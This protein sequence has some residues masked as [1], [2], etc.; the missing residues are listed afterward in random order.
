M[1]AFALKNWKYLLMGILLVGIGVQTTRLAWAKQTIAENEA[2]QK[3]AINEAQHKAD[4]LAGDLIIAQ[5]AAMAVT[6]KTV[7]SY[8]DRIVKI[9]VQTACVSSA[10]ITTGFDGVRTIL[11]GSEANPTTS[12]SH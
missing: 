10:A 9:P 1:I 11:R 5:A 6:E 3:K 7:T 12:P 4:I 2:A 8:V